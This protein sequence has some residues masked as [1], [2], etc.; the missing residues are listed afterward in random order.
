MTNK[1][2]QKDFRLNEHHER[3]N[4]EILEQ[5]K[6]MRSNVTVREALAQ[7]ERIKKQSNRHQT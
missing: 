1:P 2:E 3:R 5:V 7:Y 4:A 6:K